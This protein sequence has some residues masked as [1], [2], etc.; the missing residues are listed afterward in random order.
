MKVNL[1]CI[2]AKNV[3][4]IDV[5]GKCDAY[6]K[7][8]FGKQKEKTRTIDNSLTPRWRQEFIFDI[9]DFQKDYLY[10]QLYDRDSLSRDD[11]IADVEIYTRFLQPGIII[12]QW[13]MMK[14]KIKDKNPEIHLAIHIGQEKDTPFIARPFQILITNIRVISAKDIEENEYSVSVGYKKE[15]MKETRKSNDLMWQE[16]FALAM[17]LDEPSLIVNLNKGKSI[18]GKTKIFMGFDVGVIEKKWFPLEG[19][20]SIKLAL[21]IAPNYVQPFLGEKFDDLPVPTEFTAY[22]R[23]IEG[24]SLTSM[25][26]NGKNDAYCTVVNLKTPKKIKKTQILYKTDAPKWNYFI[27]V[28]IHDYL[29]DVIRLSCY[30]Y[31]RLNSNDLIGYVDLPIKDL[32]DGQIIDRW[33]NIKNSETGSGGQLHIMHQICT[34]G[35]IPFNPVIPNEIKK[36]HVHIMDGYDIP[37]TDL[38][39]KTDPYLRIKLN[40]QEFFQKTNVIDNTLTPLWNET[41]TLYS[42]Y[43]N[44]SIQLELKDDGPGKDPIIGTKN[45]EL[46]Y[47]A[48]GEIKEITE[49]LIPA[50][51]MKKGGIIHL[52]IQITPEMP[53]IGV[54]FTRHIDTGKKT[55]KGNGC[56]DSIGQIP[57]EKSTALFIK[58]IQAF[59]LKA[60]DSN[61]LSDPYII[62][63]IDKQKK[64]TSIISE[65]L[66]PKW[67]EYFIFD[68]NS[69]ANDILQIDCMDHNAIAKDSLIGFA[70]IPIKSLKMGEINKLNLSLKRKN[71]NNSGI[72]YLEIH[73]AKKGDIPFK[74]RIWTPEVFNIRILEGQLHKGHNFYFA[75]KFE[76][77]KDFQFL[78]TQQK[79][80][81]WMEE[82]QM[83][84]STKEKII[85]KLFE[86][87]DKE[88]EKGELIIDFKELKLQ[89]P[90]DKIYKIGSKGT[91]HLI[92]EKNYLG[93]HSFKGLPL[94]DN[95]ENS[96]I[97]QSFTFNI[98]IFEANDVPSMDSNGKSDPYIKLYLLGIKPKEKIGEVKTKIRFKTLNPIW[99]DEFHFPIKSIGTDV[100][101][102]SFK[103]Y[104]TFGRDDKISSYDIYMK[105]VNIGEIR[106]E[107]VPF[108]SEK[109]VSKG[110]I[111]HI[112][113]QLTAPGKIPYTPDE[114]HERRTLNI[115]ILEA[116]EIKAMNINGF[117]DPFCQMYILGDRIYLNTT[118]KKETLSP[119]WDENFSFLITDYSKDIFVLSLKNSNKL[120]SDEEIGVANL[121][122]NKFEISKVYKKWI[123][124]QKKGKKTGL[125]KILIHVSNE[126][127][128][129]F[130]GEI[131]ED[132]IPLFPSDRWEINLSLMRASNLPSADSNGLSDPYCLMNILNTKISVKSR[133]ID[134][135]INPMWDENFRIPIQSLNSDILRIEVIDWDKIGKHDKLAMIDFSLN[136]FQPGIVY[137]N[138][139]P[140]IPLIGNSKNST[141]ELAFQ[142][143]PPGAVPFS[144]YPFMPDQIN[145]RIEQ[146]KGLKE[147][148]KENKAFF[149]LKLESDTNEG[150]F[151]SVKDKINSDF[152]ECFSFII[153]DKNK[154]KL[155]IE[156]KDENNKNSLICKCLIPLSIL[157]YEKT[158][159]LNIPMEPSGNIN[160]Y[161][162]INKKDK[163]PFTDIILAPISNPYMTLYIK[164]IS[165]RQIPSADS[166]GLSDPY[167]VLELLNRKDK[168][169]TSIKKQTLTPVWNQEFQFKIF[170]L[171][172]DV[173]I[174]SLY[175]Y[176]KYSK[177]DLLGEWRKPI[178]DLRPGIV[179]EE[180]VN[181]GGM[182]H[183]I[184]HLACANQVKW[185]SKEIWPL[186]LHIRAIEAKDIPN[187]A[188][189]T[190]PYLELFFIHDILKEKTTTK[191]NTL[192]PQWF[193]DFHFI[194]TDLNEAF[195][196]KLWDENTLKNSELSEAIINFSMNHKI[197]TVYDEW[198]DMTP[199]GSN[200]KGGKVRLMTQLADY[201]TEPFKGPKNPPPPY[202][203]SETKML[204]N[205][206][207]IRAT[208]IEGMDSDSSDPY[209][210]LEFEG[211]PDSIK[212]TR[213]IENSLNPF[214][215]EF[216]Q[217]EIHSLSD[218][219]KI[220]LYDYDKV[221][222]DDII[223]FY[224][225]DLSKIKYG[226]TYE[227]ILKMNPYSS[228]IK[229]PGDISVIYQV[230][231]PNQAIFFSKEFAVNELK[232]YIIGFENNTN[233]DEYF[234]EVKTADAFK[235]KLSNVTYD[236]LIMETFNLLLRPYQIETLE[237]ILYRNE[238][239]GKF[240]F[241]KEV[242]RIRHTIGEMGE[243]NIEGIK[244]IL[245]M[246]DQNITFPHHPPF[247]SPKRCV[248]IYI[249]R[250]I[251]LPKMDKKSSDPFIKITLN[252]YKKK[253][254]YTN[255]TRVIMKEV[256]PIYKHVFHIPAY[257]IRDDIISIK[258]YDYDSISKCDL[259][260]K[261]EFKI[262]EL[263]YG[264]VRDEWYNLNKGKIHLLTHFSDENQP[265]FE[266]KIFIPYYL[267]IKILETKE[268][269]VAERKSLSVYMKN[270]LYPDLNIKSSNL[271]KTPQ[272]LDGNFSLP[273]TNSNDAYIIETVDVL[274]K[275]RT[276]FQTKGLQPGLI[277]RN[278][279]NGYR[280]WAQ[281]L[282]QGKE[283]DPFTSSNFYDYY[284]KVPEENYTLHIEVM[285][286]INL[287]ATDSDGT[288]DPYFIA[289]LGKEQY[290]SR[291]VYSNL[292]PL[293]YEEF[294]LKVQNLDEKL[295]IEIF[296]KDKL[297]KDDLLGKLEIDL[298]SEKFGKVTEKEY[299]LEKG[300]VFM[301]WQVTEP[302]QS[303][304]T[305]K[306]FNVNVLN[307]NIGKYESL[308]NSYEFWRLKLDNNI[309]QTM[310]TPCGAFNET[311]SF[312]LTGQRQIV[313]EQYNLD[314]DNYPKLINSIPFN[315]SNSQT[316][317]F[318]LIE[319]LTGIYEIVPY[320]TIPFKGQQFP[321]YFYP[322][323]N[324][325]LAVFIY[326]AKNLDGDLNKPPD[327]YILFKYKD[328]DIL[329]QKSRRFKSTKNPVW[330]QYFNFDVYSISSDILN[331]YIMDKDKITKDDKMAKISIEVSNLLNF[332]IEKKLYS[333][334]ANGTI[335]IQTQL[336][337]PNFIPF[338]NISY[339][340]D[341]VYI[342]FL[343]GKKLN[344]G[345]IYCCCKFTNDITWKK[346]RTINNS[347]NPQ[348]NE[349]IKL[350]IT[351]ISNDIE[352]QVKNENL[353][354]DTKFGKIEIKMNEISTKTVKKVSYLNN[355]EI[356]YLIQIGKSTFIPFSDYQEVDEKITANNLMLAVKVI[357]AHNLK[358][359]DG[360]TS[361]PYC[362]LKVAGIEKKTRVIDCTLNPIWK[363]TFYFDIS[364]YSTNELLIKI[365]DK[366]KLSKDD[367]LYQITLP[368]NKL[369]CG[370]VEDKWHGSLHLVTHL[371]YP[372]Q[373]SF[374]SKLF[375]PISKIVHIQNIS[376]NPEVFC[377]IQLK[378]DE[379]WRYT[380][381]GDFSDYFKMEY[382]D[383]SIISVKSS[384]L[385]N[386]SEEININIAEAV[387][388]NFENS[389][390][391]FKINLVNEIIPF[392][393]SIYWTCNIFIKQITNIKKKKDKLY[394]PEINNNSLGFTYDGNIYKYLSLHINSLQTDELKIVLY[395][396]KKGKQK[397]YAKCFF[398][399]FDLQPGIIE[400][401]S[402]TFVKHLILG[403]TKLINK[404]IILE[405]HITPPNYQPF[406]NLKFNPLIMHIY[407]IE[408]LNIPK[409]DIASKT[410]PYALFKFDGDKIG[411]KS[412]VLEN[413]LNP[414]WNE[415]IDL[416]IINPNE[417]LALELWD[418]NNKKDK[419][420]CS[421]KLE[422]K[423]YMDFEPH[424]EWIKI[425]KVYLNLAIQIKQLGDP[426][427]TK[428]D[429]QLYQATSSI[430]SF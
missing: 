4:K 1:K 150:L 16:E 273:I 43:S 79:E 425:N 377:L 130:E 300:S 391:K 57:V 172:T 367:L 348:W 351:N 277:Y 412:T 32:G 378:G 422:T 147:N 45:I 287:K 161:L 140:L 74:E 251:D 226:F 372:G 41:F 423:K 111:V 233:G 115:K 360:N 223:S 220:T 47:I 181:A 166:T 430:P 409:M 267:N 229:N 275:N 88:N 72:L 392:S 328:R 235:G 96:F 361:D 345:D 295:I 128:K 59:D 73:V 173:I 159:E 22:F 243:K 224:N 261:L 42:L 250:C 399:L 400:E 89:T 397:E 145:I 390:G 288:S 109:G 31:D 142:I 211:F 418:K 186:R 396:N 154:D 370:I 212:K 205:I 289:K 125:I 39:G 268:A 144:N 374:E 260:G 38:M 414:Q 158:K 151:S 19:K 68:L 157:E 284:N 286:M 182:I 336:V 359:A 179:V 118:V 176:D 298:T 222:K 413:T 270:D 70:A 35:W 335:L 153:T 373:L 311:F 117:S 344:F 162:Q 95:K 236:N 297:S 427:I 321:L 201:N 113:Y 23:I 290:K 365:F 314:S 282:P 320:G 168:K 256:N 207:I 384:N 195:K 272:F 101:H 190:D 371:M 366:D 196:I 234:C 14:S 199:L 62:L 9:L 237:I 331:I 99:N 185:E 428:E 310:I 51:G 194:I 339:S 364:S 27:N 216:F 100:L 249:D 337:P 382:V 169:K 5:G 137:Q 92:C 108:N 319:N 143:T 21:Q 329:K 174:L 244:F 341:M 332:N 420:I 266:E 429:V 135:S 198:Y 355:G 381:K 252:K 380:K 257:S 102:L 55:K 189:K 379:F 230:T 346:T 217:F 67:D 421:T 123:E 347:K 410:D 406:V 316:G 245:A 405:M 214:W 323:Q 317:K 395:K 119:F 221:S 247:I 388:K 110:G 375:T 419:I 403:G 36:I 127:E 350:P 121:E 242:K 219:F 87:K 313:F 417:D 356:S 139:Y 188:G 13:Y 58:I 160:L 94:L 246:N 231:E 34:I 386:T 138:I 368:I 183:I 155:L 146:I 349:I 203:I 15:L 202:P 352:I 225:L 302:G 69:L 98:K 54:T 383:N 49:E 6:C 65:C 248:H 163:L 343:E 238:M 75:G 393:P 303:R 416:Y 296:D 333:V 426:F 192:T 63:K 204:F 385:K 210:K 106:D 3:P 114:K 315:F 71:G 301:K 104:D 53:F 122:I 136:N 178:K 50:K 191:D 30:D 131:I 171:N 112:K 26:L 164:V 253:K 165:G 394:L 86:Y 167:C 8:Q 269:S 37:K 285:K 77:D 218:I 124:V 2:E 7:I 292:N 353:I 177:N 327:P 276:E 404:R 180:E 259:I 318:N 357:E 93:Y 294:K 64:N 78:S 193:Q 12:D 293:F 240:K 228:S 149:N 141:I 401:K 265:S 305:E 279:L 280:F 326:D 85:I 187:N 91:I 120:K 254:R 278:N 369:Q 283:E 358:A 105:N 407:L 340:Y 61:G 116:K 107:W 334:G 264:L 309:K 213:I 299:Y 60:C 324:W 424:Y 197:N 281:I 83:I 408:A 342:K 18:I 66:N 76:G 10:I 215:D 376:Y 17:P 362:V 241:A 208:E 306:I 363:Q 322:K 255:R 152:K 134:K 398:K 33:V 103:D 184:Y 28:K 170:S 46:N 56:L 402:I 354:K 200:K 304:W 40:D 175:D 338:S 11:L 387:E 24:R 258:V 307:I 133:R 29:S 156:Y 206:K 271:S 148:K 20:G 330:N 232:V 81:N 262:S 132:R 389:L 82:Y 263:S 44:P 274:I 48:P 291:V 97:S 325:S 80:N 52:Y 90:V 415:L 239:K 25:D 126:L 209:C 227:E 84:Y 129:P 411:V 308:K 312:I